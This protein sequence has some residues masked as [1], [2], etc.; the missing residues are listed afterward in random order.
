MDNGV[1]ED[2]GRLRIFRRRE[3]QHGRLASRPKGRGE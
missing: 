3:V 2:R 1:G